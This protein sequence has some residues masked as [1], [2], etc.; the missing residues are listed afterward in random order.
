MG[1]TLRL[2]YILYGWLSKCWSL[3]GNPINRDPNFDNYP[4]EYMDP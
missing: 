4:Y 1:I 2:M 3:F